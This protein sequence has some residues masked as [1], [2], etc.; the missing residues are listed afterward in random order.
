[1][2]V[3]GELSKFLAEENNMFVPSVRC[4]AKGVMVAARLGSGS[5]SLC[6]PQADLDHPSCI[7]PC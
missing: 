2:V 5:S 1:M 3:P 7:N 4:V 6:S